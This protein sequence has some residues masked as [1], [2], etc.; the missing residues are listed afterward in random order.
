[1][2]VDL[3]RQKTPFQQGFGALE[4]ALSPGDLLFTGSPPG[5]GAMRGQFLKPGDIIESSITYLGRQKN[6]VVA[7][8]AEGRAPT[9]GPFITEW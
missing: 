3:G 2:L 4:I 1:M 7:E 8:N 9:F 5:N 6:L